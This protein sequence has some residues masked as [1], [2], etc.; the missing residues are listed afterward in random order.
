MALHDFRCQ[1]QECRVVWEDVATLHDVDFTPSC[2]KCGTEGKKTVSLRTRGPTFSEKLFPF[3]HQGLGEVVHSEKHMKERCETAG[4][5]SKHE[6]GFM[7]PKHER[8]LMQKRL[9]NS[10]REV[11]EKAT[12]SGK[13]AGLPEFETYDTETG[14][15][16]DPEVFQESE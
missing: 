8:R 16:G 15:A 6:G 4:L 5:Y 1:N 10:P 3:Y 11:V 7:T 14:E 12:W 13:G 2:P 9:D